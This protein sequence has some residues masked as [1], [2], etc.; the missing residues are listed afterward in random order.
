M[1]L[2]QLNTIVSALLFTATIAM[3]SSVY[4][5]VTQLQKPYELNRHYFSLLEK[6]S[7]KNRLLIDRYLQTGNLADLSVAQVFIREELPNSLQALPLPLQRDVLPI[8]DQLNS[9]MQHEL[10]AAGKLAGNIQGLLI[11][12]ERETLAALE[13]L[14]E[15]VIAFRNDDNHLAADALQQQLILI[16]QGIA[17]RMLQRE[18]YFRSSAEQV[19]KSIASLNRDISRQVSVLT[20]L[21][22][23]GVLAVAEEDDFFAMLELTIEDSLV[24]PVIVDVAEDLIADLATLVRRYPAELER[25]SR[26]IDRATG[27]SAEVSTIIAML[28]DAVT[29]SKVYIDQ[30]RTAIE[31]QVYWLLSFFIV[32]LL[33]TGGVLLF[34]Q[35]KAMNAIEGV[36]A[37]LE[38]LCSGNFSDK[39]DV[40]IAFNELQALALNCEKLQGFMVGLIQG[41]KLQTDNVHRASVNISDNSIKI[42]YEAS[43]Q[44]EHTDKVA[45]AVLALLN[46]FE[47]VHLNVQEATD[48][49]ALGQ[50]AVSESVV[51]VSKLQNNIQGLSHEVERG[52]ADIQ[53]LNQ[54]TKNI[55]KVLSVI[56]TIASQTNLLALNAAIEAARAGESGRG[57]AVVAS[58]VRVLAQLTAESTHEISKI[59]S[60]LQLSAAEVTDSMQRQHSIAQISIEGAAEVVERLGAVELIIEKVDAVNQLI[61]EQTVQQGDAVDDVK[62]SIN[63]VQTQLSAAQLRVNSTKCQANDLTDVCEILNN[64]VAQYSV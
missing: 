29:N 17:Q 8:I 6:I 64:Q 32:L 58:E 26:L 47:K 23:L 31:H 15:Y 13:S 52:E 39:L 42:E 50:Q 1:R 7:V 49:V 63:Q 55:E 16:G 3:G 56:G 33:V 30:E 10:L 11:Q 51:V 59:L 14:Q 19:L 36:A 4:W 25:T 20:T 5:G 38:K 45:D 2:A 34:S 28:I 40:S 44:T 46:S 21:T 57:F 18:K 53:K 60:A 61:S 48:S 43:L 54:D 41:I 27:A 9:K 22:L 62:L 37:Y 24:D 35:K 12:N